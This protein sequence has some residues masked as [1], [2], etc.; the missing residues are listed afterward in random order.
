MTERLLP[1][2]ALLASCALFGCNAQT[3][4][5]RDKN[6]N[7]LRQCSASAQCGAG[8]QCVCGVCS[9]VCDRDEQCGQLASGAV[10]TTFASDCE[11]P[12]PVCTVRCGDDGAC[13]AM[14]EGLMCS[15]GACMP[16]T[17]AGVSLLPDAGSPDGGATSDASVA[18]GGR[19]GG[20]GPF[21]ADCGEAFVCEDLV[22]EQQAVGDIR[23]FAVD[24]GEFVYWADIGTSDTQGN[25][26][27]DGAIV[28]MPKAGRTLERVQQGLDRPFLVWR[29][30]G[31]SFWL[32]GDPFDFAQGVGMQTLY[33]DPLGTD[34]APLMIRKGTLVDLHV[35]SD[36]L[37]WL[38]PFTHEA[39]GP[40]FNVN[41]ARL[42]W[43]DGSSYSSF[44]PGE[45]VIGTT[46]GGHVYL[47]HGGTDILRMA[48]GGGETKEI[49]EDPPV[50]LASIDGERLWVLHDGA[51]ISS[52]P[53]TGGPVTHVASLGT[54]VGRIQPGTDVVWL[55]ALEPAPQ[56]A[57]APGVSGADLPRVLWSVPK[58]GGDPER[59][60]T[61]QP[62]DLVKNGIPADPVW[63]ADGDTAWVFGY[64]TVIHVHKP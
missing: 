26:R 12:A 29:D 18:A 32:T 4:E 34:T 55:V 1:C 46:D 49:V 2:L 33:G 19:D 44:L 17:A 10:C 22:G 6:T 39:S 63:I 3:T 59:A 42:E 53:S 61:W 41:G 36:M 15:G 38:E 28:R 56:V 43:T 60:F 58:A 40:G 50:S 27:V 45:Y 48:V 57:G 5:N 16:E 37:V 23:D 20:D 31:R 24:D 11:A 35:V 30:G 8:L 25:S 64:G 62:K 14:G 51:W 52:M 13:A 54:I 21:A 47:E 9:S 7:W